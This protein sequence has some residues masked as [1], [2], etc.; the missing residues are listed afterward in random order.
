[1][2]GPRFDEATPLS[3]QSGKLHA[4]SDPSRRLQHARNLLIAIVQKR[5]IGIKNGVLIRFEWA[6]C[7]TAKNHR[8][9]AAVGVCGCCSR[10]GGSSSVSEASESQ[11]YKYYVYTQASLASIFLRGSQLDAYESWKPKS[12]FCSTIGL[13]CNI[14]PSCDSNC[15]LH[16]ET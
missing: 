5:N 1:M 8:C 10:L 15:Y 3:W 9:S 12:K 2:C 6:H 16:A 11:A 7:C 13:R 14:H 4:W